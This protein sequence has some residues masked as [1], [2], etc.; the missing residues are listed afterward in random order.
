MMS[1]MFDSKAP[2]EAYKLYNALK[3]HFES[4]YDAVKYQ[5]KT[6]VTP[7]SFFKRKDKYFFAKL[8]NKHGND[9]MKYYVANFINDVKYVGD[10]MDSDGETNYREM[11]KKHESI[12]YVFKNDINKLSAEVTSF[13]DLFEKGNGTHPRIVT[14]LLEEEICLE[15]VVILNKLTGFMR[16]A[17]KEITETIV[18]PELSRK[19]KK[20]DHFILCDYDKM[21]NII[22]KAFTN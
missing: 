10:M 5:F 15:T 18:W 14:L 16:K 17:D 21:K 8:A 20:Y 13:D 7:Q 2:F 11:L 22:I 3:L 12:S 1:D 4:D 19:I 9:L 6:R